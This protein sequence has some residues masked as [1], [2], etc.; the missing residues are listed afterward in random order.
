MGY[1][2]KK[3]EERKKLAT[4]IIVLLTTNYENSKVLE[5]IK[6]KILEMI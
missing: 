6:N 2:S 5:T 4:D 1:Y 3:R